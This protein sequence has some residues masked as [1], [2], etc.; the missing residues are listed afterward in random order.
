[1]NAN[2]PRPGNQV[3]AL[4]PTSVADIDAIASRIALAEWAPKAYFGKDGKPNAAKIAVGIMHGMELGLTPMAALQSIAVV[5]GQPALWG[6]GLM[7]VV[8]A[9]GLLE[10]LHEDVT[11]EGKNMVAVC[12]V[13]RKGMTDAT[14]TFSMEDAVKAGLS[15]KQGPWSQYPKRML[16]LR[17]RAFA[18]RDT[19]ADVLRGMR[20]VEELQDVA[21]QPMTDVTPAEK[22]KRSDYVSDPAPTTPPVIDVQEEPEP[23]T[24]PAPVQKDPPAPT[25]APTPAPSEF[26]P[27]GAPLF[28]HVGECI[29]E[30]ADPFTMADAYAAELDKLNSLEDIKT[31]ID[32]NSFTIKDFGAEEATAIFR[33]A[34]KD[35]LARV[36]ASSEPPPQDAAPAVPKLANDPNSPH[37]VSI[38]DGTPFGQ[39]FTMLLT[40]TREFEAAKDWVEF[41]RANAATISE[42]KKQMPSWAK[43]LE[44]TIRKGKGE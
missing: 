29:G 28:D 44:D 32:N 39:V 12:K 42:F 6:D 26:V 40:P 35:A 5:N 7:A 13:R 41:E 9:S 34:S 21:E 18:L 10:A 23:T 11:G 15:G 1:M 31:M 14:R 3:M 17:A 22:P 25:P 16:Q 27:P 2:S 30:Y 37:F 36:R 43:R 33:E 8:Q 19:F 4:V 38:P 24:T 20:T